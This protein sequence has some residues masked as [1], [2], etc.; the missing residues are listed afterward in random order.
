MAEARAFQQSL[1]PD[2]EAVVNRLAIC[3][4]YTPCSGARRRF[5]RLRR[6]DSGQ[7]ALLDRRRLGARRVGGDADRHREERI[8]RLATSTGTSRLPSCSGSGR[9]LAAFGPGT[10][11]H[12]VRRADRPGRGTAA[13]C[14]R[15]PSAGRSVGRRARARCGWGAPVRWSPRCCRRPTWEVGSC[16]SMRAIGCCCTRT[17]SRR[18]S[19]TPTAVPTR[20]SEEAIGRASRGG[21][22]LLDAILDDVHRQ[23]AERPQPDDL[24]L[25]TASVLA[26]PR[27][28]VRP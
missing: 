18:C 17:A 26:P 7:T 5:V 24:T 14:E 10:I 13:I 21:A 4:R 11:R 22:E 25:M 3:C 23:L 15:G 27:G 19:R 6:G 20:D 16:R 9:G 2:R 8:S 28:G 1:L 12:A